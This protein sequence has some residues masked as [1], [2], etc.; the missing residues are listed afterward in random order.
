MVRIVAELSINTPTASSIDRYK[1]RYGCG[2]GGSGGS[3]GNNGL[4]QIVYKRTALAMGENMSEKATTGNNTLVATQSDVH[5][6]LE[7]QQMREIYEKSEKEKEKEREK[8]REKNINRNLGKINYHSRTGEIFTAQHSNQ[9][10]VVLIF[11][12]KTGH[13]TRT[14]TEKVIWKDKVFE[15]KQAWFSEMAKLSIEHAAENMKIV[16]CD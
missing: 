5:Q 11:D 8:E 12:K 15:T 16:R 10:T 3:G 2:S 13:S 6:K 4:Q 14:Q 9:M 1:Y 7:T